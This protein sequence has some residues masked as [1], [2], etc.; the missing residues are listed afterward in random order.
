MFA[1]RGAVLSVG[2]LVY[3]GGLV[4]IKLVYMTSFLL[5]SLFI[6]SLCDIYTNICSSQSIDAEVTFCTFVAA[7]RWPA[8]EGWGA[9][10]ARLVWS[11]SARGCW[12]RVSKYGVRFG[13]QGWLTVRQL[14]VVQVPNKVR[15]AGIRG[16]GNVEVWSISGVTLLRRQVLEFHKKSFCCK[17]T[18]CI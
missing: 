9:I 6:I 8:A 10:P 3:M 18:G 2:F 12:A 7:F 11:P 13:T 14:G 4:Y 15:A 1:S 17:I 16:K 5:N